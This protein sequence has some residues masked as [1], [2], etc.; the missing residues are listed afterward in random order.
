[1]CD[2]EDYSDSGEATAIKQSLGKVGYYSD[3]GS[4]RRRTSGTQRQVSPIVS[5]RKSDLS[6]LLDNKLSEYVEPI[7]KRLD[8]WED[9]GILNS[10]STTEAR[11]AA[12][13]EENHRLREE[14]NS[15][16]SFSRRN[17]IRIYGLKETK[18]EVCESVVLNILK[19]ICPTF[20]DRTFERVHRLGS[21][22]SNRPML[23][24][25]FHF[26]DKMFLLS[27]RS[28]L[29]KLGLKISD[30]FSKTVENNRKPLISVLKEGHKLGLK[31]KL[32][33]DKLY[34]KGK[35]YTSSNMEDLPENLQPQ[36][37]STKSQ[38]GITAFFTSHSP[39][40]NFYP[41]KFQVNDENFNCAEQYLT[42]AKARLFN[43]H[44]TVQKLFECNI[45]SI[46][47][48]IAKSITHYDH[49]T[50]IQE[51]ESLVYDGILAKFS[52][53]DYL[54]QFLLSTGSTLLVEASSDPVWGIG[55]TMTDPK[56][57][58]TR[59]HAKGNKLGK[60]LMKIRTELNN[61]G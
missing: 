49:K 50:W 9:A 31:P 57:W 41:S 54:R 29:G 33:G 60:I 23:C 25:I 18:E 37:I 42:I 40:S 52:Q 6:D 44:E 46:Q 22:G 16:Q 38:N 14:V 28:D 2:E 17:N 47:K 30:D 15:L 45:P 8:S 20:N 11:I 43:D 32:S 56:I 13:E 5:L 26:K 51:S 1:M 55:L 34:L 39:L 19:D 4:K 35:T 53:S 36:Y 10:V 21:Y 48:K 61:S 7:L 12:L 3:G 58:D 59:N 24:K 27:K